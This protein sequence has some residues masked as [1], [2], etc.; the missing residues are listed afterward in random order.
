MLL[1]Q[2]PTRGVLSIRLKPR[3]AAGIWGP[4]IYF[5]KALLP[6]P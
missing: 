6:V 3:D 1:R 4:S 2:Y 5:A